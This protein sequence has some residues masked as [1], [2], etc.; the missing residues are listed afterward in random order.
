MKHWKALHRWDNDTYLREQLGDM[1][2]CM[3]A[4]ECMVLSGSED[5]QMVKEGLEFKNNFVN[6]DMLSDEFFQHFNQPHEEKYWYWYGQV[7]QHLKKDVHPHEFLWV[8]LEDEKA[9]GLFMWLSDPYIGPW[10]HYDQDHNFYVQVSGTKRFIMFPPWEYEHIYAYPR[11][12]PFWHKSQVNFD[13][14]D[15][16]K[17]PEFAKAQGYVADLKQGDILYIPPYWWHHVRSKERSVSLASW[18]QSGVFKKMRYDLYEREFTF[19]REEGEKKKEWMVYFIKELIREVYPDVSE[20]FK[21]MYSLRWEP[22]GIKSMKRDD[23]CQYVVVKNDEWDERIK[24]D[25]QY[26]VEAF[27]NCQYVPGDTEQSIGPNRRDM[28][29]IRNVEM[30][31]FIEVLL[32]DVIGAMNVSTFIEMCLM[33]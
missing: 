31:E 11:I 26:A 8:D 21:K 33:K 7:P 1:K 23:I 16:E 25:V 5:S 9:F 13:H 28:M 20:F 6:R 12:H 15:L 30:M 14:P 17:H 27:S 24:E 22:L 3:I 32:V 29:A 19:D 4:D 2:E 10:L 18:S